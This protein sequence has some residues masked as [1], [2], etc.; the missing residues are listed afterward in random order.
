MCEDVS[1]LSQR[2]EVPINVSNY[3]VEGKSKF[4]FRRET[5]ERPESIK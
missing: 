1:E 4:D 2:F 5:C 3:E